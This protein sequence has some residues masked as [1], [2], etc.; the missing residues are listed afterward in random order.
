MDVSSETCAGL[1]VCSNRTDIKGEEF[2]LVEE[3]DSIETEIDYSALYTADDVCIMS[4]VSCSVK[5]PALSLSS[6]NFAGSGYNSP[7]DGASSEDEEGNDTAL[8]SSRQKSM[9]SAPTNSIFAA[10]SNSIKKSCNF[11]LFSFYY[12]FESTFVIYTHSGP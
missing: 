3:D 1:S 8:H 11:N 10:Q 6:A 9:V 5:S 2:P 4:P 12:Y 7:V